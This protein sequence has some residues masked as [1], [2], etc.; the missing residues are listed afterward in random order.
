MRGVVLYGPPASGKDTIT[1]ALHELNSRYVLFPRIKCGTGKTTGYRLVTAY[2]LNDLRER[3][4]LI[5]ENE[6]YGAVYAVDRPGLIERMSDHIPVL[7]L[8]QVQAV[9]AIRAATPG[10][11]WLVVSSST[12]REIAGERIAARGDTDATDRLTAW[13]ATE[14]LRNADLRIDTGSLLP[15]HA[16]GAIHDALPAPAASR[17]ES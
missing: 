1:R 14:P 9:G 12:S 7:H 8:G 17:A 5:W 6:R 4:E 15:A 2:Q 3:G 10:A 16:A 13:D 11:R